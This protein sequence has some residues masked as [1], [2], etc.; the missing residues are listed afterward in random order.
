LAYAEAFI[1][2]VNEKLSLKKVS[3]GHYFSLFQY[4]FKKK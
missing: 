3:F 1:H 4:L 2:L